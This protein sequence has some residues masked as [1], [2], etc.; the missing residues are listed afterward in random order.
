VSEDKN[1]A[2]Y[3]RQKIKAHHPNHIN[4]S[5]KLKVGTLDVLSTNTILVEVDKPI[6]INF[7]D[8]EDLICI[9]NLITDPSKAE[10]SNDS[11]LTANKT[12]VF[13]LY[14]FVKD[15]TGGGGSK[16]PFRVGVYEDREL[17]CSIMINTVAIGLQPLFTCTYYLGEKI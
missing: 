10:Y 8:A 13:N 9:F 3:S 2:K 17:Y 16:Y 12:I 6:E 7:G 5:M 14:N 1:G 11:V 15:Q 4:Q